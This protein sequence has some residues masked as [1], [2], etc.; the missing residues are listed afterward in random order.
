VPF[1]SEKSVFDPKILAIAFASIEIITKIAI[2]KLSLK[3]VVVMAFI[4]VTALM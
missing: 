1:S 4:C 2:A 3:I